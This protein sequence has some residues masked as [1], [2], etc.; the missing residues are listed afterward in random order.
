MSKRPRPAWVVP[1]VALFAAGCL[2]SDASER[3]TPSG[4]APS[5]S[6]SMRFAYLAPGPTDDPLPLPAFSAASLAL[7]VAD[8]EEGASAV[9]DLLGFPEGPETLAETLDGYDAV[10]LGPG[11]SRRAVES[12]SAVVGPDGIPTVSLSGGSASDLYVLAPGRGGLAEAMV[13]AAG[14]RSC[15]A[16]GEGGDRLVR[17]LARYVSD[18]VGERRDPVRVEPA[19]GDAQ[20][21]ATELLDAGCEAVLWSGPPSLGGGLRAALAAAGAGDAPFVG[22]DELRDDDFR[23]AAGRSALGATIVSGARDVSTRLG[24]EVR[25]F[26]QD[27]QAEVGS[28]PQPFAVEGWD[29]AFLLL[30]AVAD[31][32]PRIDAWEGLW[33]PYDFSG[34]LEP[35]AFA[36]VLQGPRWVLVGS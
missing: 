6:A 23:D 30:R 21:A 20:R 18:R 35:T 11:A 12:V 10:I 27:Y 14:P 13:A 8:A 4:G 5:A 19:E 34:A 17:A 25:R 29:A 36:Y 22:T 16:W 31:G 9:I 7:R 33:G 1:L 2:A 28:P 15:I 32:S 26:I 24:L 3:V